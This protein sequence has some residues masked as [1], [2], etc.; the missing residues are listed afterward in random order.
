MFLP[1][2]LCI[3]FAASLS[4]LFSS[5]NLFSFTCCS[6]ICCF[7]SSNCWAIAW[8]TLFKDQFSCFSSLNFSL[9]MFS[10]ACLAR[11]DISMNA[12]CQ[13]FQ[14]FNWYIV[15]TIT[16]LILQKSLRLESKNNSNIYHK[17]PGTTVFNMYHRALSI[18][19]SPVQDEYFFSSPMN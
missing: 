15:L 8:Y 12:T 6:S 4:F 10:R 2:S 19:L 9:A 7:V 3:F 13:Y 11:M 5:S 14:Y 17:K 16:Y 1:P 18:L